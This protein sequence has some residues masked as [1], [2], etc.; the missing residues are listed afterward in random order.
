MAPSGNTTTDSLTDSLPL[1]VASARIVREYEGVMPQLVDIE[2]LGEGNGLSW[3]EVL[4]AKLNAQAITESTIFNNPQLLSDSLLSGTPTMVGV[5]T[6]ITD[7]VAAKIA[8]VAYGRLGTLAQNAIQRL[9]DTDGLTMLDSATTSLG[10]AGTTAHSGLVAT[11]QTRIAGNT[12]EQG[13]PPYRAVLHPFQ[14]KDFYDEITAGIGTYPDV[15][16]FTARVFHEGFKGMVSGVQ[17]YE[18]GNISIDS[19][20]D[21]KG[22]VFAQEGVI[23]VQGMGL[24]TKTREEPHIGGGATSVWIYDEYIYVERSAGNWL[25]EIYTDA[26]APTS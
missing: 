25:Y 18:D 23:L 12:I 15:S 2:N 6:L 21:A 11:A 13:M 14:V 24:R 22:G 17:I 4:F 16:E 26:L 9:K 19:S 5:H 20:D 3:N 1:V 10:G 8:S 7:R